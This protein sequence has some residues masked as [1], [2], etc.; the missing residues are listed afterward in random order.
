MTTKEAVIIA[1]NVVLAAVGVVLYVEGK[2]PIGQL[3][4]F[5]TAIG[6]PSAGS[7]LKLSDTTKGGSPLVFLIVAWFSL[8]TA[9]CALF[10]DPATEADADYLA[11]D[12][13]CVDDSK[14]LEASHACRDALRR[15]WGV[16]TV[17]V[18]KDGGQ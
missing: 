18:S 2:L 16:T 1:G 17:T 9:A 12:L 7:L 3:I 10:R 14:T 11:K 6:F 4:V 5:L 13:K 8:T 15:E